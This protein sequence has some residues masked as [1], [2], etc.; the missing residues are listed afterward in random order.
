MEVFNE[1]IKL[2]HESLP[3]LENWILNR[4]DYAIN[5]KIEYVKEYIKLFQ[6]GDKPKRFKELYCSSSK[7]RKQLEGSLYLFNSSVNINFYDKYNERV[8]K[9]LNENAK[10]D[11]L[12]LEIQCKKS[13]LYNIKN[14]SKFESLQVGEYLKKDISHKILSDYYFLVIGKG[15]YYKLKEAIEKIKNSN[16]SIS[17]KEKLIKTLNLVNKHKSVWKARD[18]CEYSIASFNRYLQLIR[19]ININPV[20]IPVRWEI[21]FLAN[22]Y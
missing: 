16:Y 4:I 1:K 15:D 17:T 6:R 13:K 9:N 18:K 22:I 7:K 21:D 2:I 5:I 11:I 10:R 19:G 3:R 14:K 8:K 12:R 20:T